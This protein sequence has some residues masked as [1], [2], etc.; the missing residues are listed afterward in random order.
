MAFKLTGRRKLEILATVVLVTLVLNWFLRR[1]IHLPRK[2]DYIT[3][4]QKMEAL[5]YPEAG[6]ETAVPNSSSGRDVLPANAVKAPAANADE[7]LDHLLK[8]P[9]WSLADD[10]IWVKGAEKVE[11]RFF[12]HLSDVRY[13]LEERKQNALGLVEKTIKLIDLMQL[14][15]IPDFDEVQKTMTRDVA[16]WNYWRGLQLNLGTYLN[17]IKWTVYAANKLDKEVGQTLMIRYLAH[18]KRAVELFGP[19]ITSFHWEDVPFEDFSDQSKCDVINQWFEA[20]TLK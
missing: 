15:A 4:S 12:F 11:S 5:K 8:I 10:R 19:H 17:S 13:S 7:W 9:S 14:E 20:I 3:G 6:G 18:A 2:D 1:S 16:R